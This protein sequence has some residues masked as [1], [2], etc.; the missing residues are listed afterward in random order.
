MKFIRK[1]FLFL[2]FIT[3]LFTGLQAKM[4]GQI[5]GFYIEDSADRTTPE[6]AIIKGNVKKSDS[7][8]ST[9]GSVY[10]NTNWKSADVMM[11][12]S[13]EVIEGIPVKMNAHHNLLEIQHDG[14]IKTIATGNIKSIYFAGERTTFITESVL[15]NDCPKGFYRLIYN[16]HSS[17]LCYYHSEIREAAYNRAIDMGNRSDAVLIKN[18]YYAL[19]NGKLLKLETSRKKLARQFADNQK[20]SGYILT[21]KIRPK[22]EFDLLKLITY[23]DSDQT[24]Q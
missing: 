1:D 17:L 21:E 4:Y 8:A 7:Q 14:K 23:V 13:D 6:N 24:G 16:R 22:N 12:G 9:G 5:R 11:N 3:A 15:K 19:I 20:V 2:L 18:D 10:I